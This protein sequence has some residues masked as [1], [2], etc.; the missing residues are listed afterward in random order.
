VGIIL[1]AAYPLEAWAWLD[2]GQME[3]GIKMNMS[4]RKVIFYCTTS[5]GS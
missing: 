4:R 2:M 5:W 1:L 3:E